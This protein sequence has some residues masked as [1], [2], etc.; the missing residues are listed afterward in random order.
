MSPAV[1]PVM[2]GDPRAGTIHAH[3]AGGGTELLI[4]PDSA[5][6]A[7][8]DFSSLDYVLLGEHVLASV[9]SLGRPSHTDRFVG[10]VGQVP[11]PRPADASA[12]LSRSQM[13]TSPSVRERQP[14]ASRQ[15]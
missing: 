2:S 4:R 3:S 1:L 15:V 12:G 9:G 14:S 13:G 5:L 8:Y 11:S 10:G 7:D 6:S